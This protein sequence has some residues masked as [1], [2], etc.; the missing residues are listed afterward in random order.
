MELFKFSMNAKST[1]VYKG[2]DNDKISSGRIP[3][4][5]LITEKN[6]VKEI[7]VVTEKVENV[8]GIVER[9]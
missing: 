2:N 1:H 6:M 3:F 9:A 4:V 5:Y 8:Y 7:R